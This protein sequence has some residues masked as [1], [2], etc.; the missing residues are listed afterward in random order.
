[1]RIGI[2]GG[3]IIALG[4]LT[5]WLVAGQ[6]SN[7]LVDLLGSPDQEATLRAVSFITVTGLFLIAAGIIAE[8][9]RTVLSTATLGISA[10][11][12]RLGGAISGLILGL[13]VTGVFV[14][15][16]A[17]LAYDYQVSI[18][19]ASSEEAATFQTKI[20]RD[21]ASSAIVPMYFEIREI[22]PTDT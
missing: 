21:L 17:G 5:G 8:A 19:H 22:F 6:L 20:K 3:A 2:I 16:L 10:I 18:S 9:I 4:L 12:D 13:A 15:T 11:L 14:M 1:M 7:E